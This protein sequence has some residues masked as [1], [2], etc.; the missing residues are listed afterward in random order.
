MAKVLYDGEIE[1]AAQHHLAGFI[2]S[3][4]EPLDPRSEQAL[5]ARIS[6]LLAAGWTPPPGFARPLP[7][8]PKPKALAAPSTARRGVE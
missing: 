7:G 4:P 8:G 3:W 1:W 2:I 6:Q 5:H